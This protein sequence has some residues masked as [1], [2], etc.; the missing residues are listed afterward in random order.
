LIAEDGSALGYF[1]AKYNAKAQTES[2]APLTLLLRR[3][4][5]RKRTDEDSAGDGRADRRSVHLRATGMA[6]SMLYTLTSD[7]QAGST[8][9]ALQLFRG[10]SFCYVSRD[11]R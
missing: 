10:G 7:R 9:I 3:F 4:A 5:A 6:A 2:S 1:T 11:F 8:I